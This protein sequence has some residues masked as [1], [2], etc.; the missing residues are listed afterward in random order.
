VGEAK[1]MRL[2]LAFAL[3]VFITAVGFLGNNIQLQSAYWSQLW[4]FVCVLAVFGIIAPALRSLEQKILAGCKRVFREVL[5]KL[6]SM[7]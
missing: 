6:G 5:L 2:K 7:L 4:S 1:K 3:F